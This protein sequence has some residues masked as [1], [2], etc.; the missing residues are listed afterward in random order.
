MARCFGPVIKLSSVV[1]YSKASLFFLFLRQAG[2]LIAWK[3]MGR[4]FCLDAHRPLCFLLTAVMCLDMPRYLPL[5]FTENLAVQISQGKKKKSH[6][7]HI[8]I[9]F[10]YTFSHGCQ[11]PSSPVPRVL[12]FC[13]NLFC[14]PRKCRE[15]MPVYCLWSPEIPLRGIFVRKPLKTQIPLDLRMWRR[16]RVKLG[17]WEP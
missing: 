12:L 9:L 17:H 3:N 11:M 4:P 6:T 13:I 15:L 14:N 2:W 7:N 5:L 16:P 10:K 8:S 1:R